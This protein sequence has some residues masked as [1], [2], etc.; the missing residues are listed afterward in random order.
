MHFHDTRNTALAN[1]F[2]AIEAGV[3]TL[4]AS[5]GGLGGCPFAPGASGNLATEDLIYVLHRAG[6]ETG[7]D[8]PALIGEGRRM[9]GRLGRSGRGRPR[10]GERL[11]ALGTRVGARAPQAR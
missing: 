3:T 1:A 2:A 7:Y 4:D 8:L 10:P 6:F 11:A 9:R 5:V